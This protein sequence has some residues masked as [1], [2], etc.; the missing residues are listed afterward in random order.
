LERSGARVNPARLGF[1]EEDFGPEED[2]DDYLE[3]ENQ[4]PLQIML[5]N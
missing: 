1:D 2:D 5:F 4:M 3:W